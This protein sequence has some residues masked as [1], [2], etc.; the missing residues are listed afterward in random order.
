MVKKALVAEAEEHT[1]SAKPA[2][3]QEATETEKCNVPA[4]HNQTEYK[5]I[6]TCGA[7]PAS[8]PSILGKQNPAA[9]LEH[10]QNPEPEHHD[11]L[12]LGQLG[13]S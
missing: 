13:A 3:D 9:G 12:P 11:M 10:G 1:Y 8:V 2:T 5:G 4:S 7:D 6:G